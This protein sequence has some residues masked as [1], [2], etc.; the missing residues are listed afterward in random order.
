MCTCLLVIHS[1]KKNS[2][3]TAENASDAVKSLIPMRSPLVDAMSESVP[4]FP[5]LAVAIYIGCV[6]GAGALANCA[7]L[8]ALIKSSKDGNLFY[9]SI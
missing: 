2:K 5:P 7:L 9:L 1:G 4:L 3:G 6:A 8:A